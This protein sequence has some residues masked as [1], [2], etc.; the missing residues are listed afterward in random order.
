MGVE[1]QSSSFNPNL[2]RTAELI[3]KDIK[4]DNNKIKEWLASYANYL[5]DKNSLRSLHDLSA[6]NK[7]NLNIIEK[8]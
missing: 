4:V 6:S 7:K 3:T 1:S 5:I 8:K 2:G